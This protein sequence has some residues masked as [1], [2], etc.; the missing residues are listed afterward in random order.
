MT[1]YKQRQAKGRIHKFSL[2]IKLGLNEPISAKN[3]NDIEIELDV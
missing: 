2:L 3:A 1:E